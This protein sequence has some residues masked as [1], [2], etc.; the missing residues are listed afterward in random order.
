M[1]SDAASL[2]AAAG[3]PTIIAAEAGACRPIAITDAAKAEIM[4][5]FNISSS[6]VSSTLRCGFSFL[7]PR[8]ALLLTVGE[9]NMRQRQVNFCKLRHI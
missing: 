9:T 5:F 6:P 1:M 2:W 8:S 7:V 3:L 4:I